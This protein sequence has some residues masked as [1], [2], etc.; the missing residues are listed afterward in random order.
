MDVHLDDVRVRIP[1]DEADGRSNRQSS[2]RIGIAFDRLDRHRRNFPGGSDQVP[3]LRANQEEKLQKKL[4]T[5][6]PKREERLNRACM[7]L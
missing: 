1:L 3:N 5:G 2:Q 7:V 4:G 6:K